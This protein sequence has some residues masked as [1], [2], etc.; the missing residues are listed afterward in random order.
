M[1]L[2]EL[3]THCPAATDPLRAAWQALAERCLQPEPAA[4][5]LAAQLAA[6]L[7]DL[8]QQVERAV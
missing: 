4:R 7:S 2:H 5:P 3:L 8:L 1:L 6:A